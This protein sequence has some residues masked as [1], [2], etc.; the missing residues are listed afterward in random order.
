MTDK[1][2]EAKLYKVA[3]KKNWPIYKQFY[4]VGACVVQSNEDQNLYIYLD[5]KYKTARLVLK[6]KYKN[7]ADFNYQFDKCHTRSLM[8]RANLLK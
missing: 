1:Q 7:E 5:H 8:R 4:D 2:L 6:D 3:L